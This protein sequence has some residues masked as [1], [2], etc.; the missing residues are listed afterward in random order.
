M[1]RYKKIG[2]LLCGMVLMMQSC[3]T[4]NLDDCPDSIRYA[5]SFIYTLH[6]EDSDRT[7]DGD[8]AGFDRFYKDVDK[9]FIYVFDATTGICV[10][11]DTAKLLSP[12][13]NDFTYSL[14]LNVGRYN[15]ITWGWG[16]SQGDKTLDIS[17]AIIPIVIPGATSINNAKLQLE[18][19]TIEGKL[20]NIFYSE[21]KNVEINAFMSRVDTMPL[22]N[23]TNTIRIVIPDALS[24]AMQD[25]ISISIVGDDGAYYFNSTNRSSDYDNGD[26]FR[27]GFNAPNILS[28]SGNVVY[29]PFNK[30]RTDSILRADPIQLVH[31]HT[32]TGRD[33]MLI[34]EISTLRLLQ[35]NDNMNIVIKW[36]GK[37][38]T[39]PLLEILQEGLTSSVQRNLDRYHRWQIV[40]NITQLSKDETFLTVHIYALDWHVVIQKEN[41]GGVW[42]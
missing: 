28:S 41:V 27:T 23:I 21:L 40:F 15:I 29:S 37:T 9:L 5:L 35:D 42:N 32:G 13:S 2:L 18:K 14:P 8:Y 6:T 39:L 34:V 30:Y 11:A 19:A 25:A 26:Y 31:P 12:F 38:I 33:S 10:Y 22:M 7:I 24:A 17:T 20:E 1:E 36:N 16:R 3:V 4:N